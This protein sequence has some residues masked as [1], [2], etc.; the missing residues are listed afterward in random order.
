MS[1]LVLSSG[2]LDTG[3]PVKI[4]AFANV[5]NAVLDPILMFSLAMG[6]QGAALATLA[7]E[8]SCHH[9]GFFSYLQ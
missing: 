2:I 6:V 8:V 7:A 9:A 5:L 1:I 4:S 3:T